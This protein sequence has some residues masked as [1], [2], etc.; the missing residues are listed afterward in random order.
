LGKNTLRCRWQMQQ[1]VFGAAVEKIEVKP[2][3]FSGTANRRR[4]RGDRGFESRSP[5]QSEKGGF[6]LPFLIGMGKGFEL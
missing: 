3:I 2:K 6:C 4:S 1:R 5:D